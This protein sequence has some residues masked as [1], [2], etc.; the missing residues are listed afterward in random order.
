MF[1]KN[2]LIL[3]L[4]WNLFNVVNHLRC[5]SYI[6]ILFSCT[7]YEYSLN[8][9][10]TCKFVSYD[11][12]LN[13]KKYL[14]SHYIAYEIT[15]EKYLFLFKISLKLHNWLVTYVGRWCVEFREVN[16]G[17]PELKGGGFAGS[18]RQ[19]ATLTLTPTSKNGIAVLDRWTLRHRWL[20]QSHH[21]TSWSNKISV[22]INIFT[23]I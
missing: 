5:S 16:V 3:N 2:W 21:R 13:P 17:G 9:I 10:F 4:Q 11:L 8:I 20:I 23:L 18:G 22:T 12:E 15:S 6:L 19:A 1:P 14:P 7:F